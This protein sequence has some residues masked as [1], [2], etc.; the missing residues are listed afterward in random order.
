M[1]EVVTWV[2]G[3]VFRDRQE[4]ISRGFRAAID[5]GIPP[6]IAETMLLR[7]GDEVSV[8]TT[9][10]TREDLQATIGSPEEPLARRLIREAGGV[11]SV[12]IF[13][14]IERASGGPGEGTTGEPTVPSRT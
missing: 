7:D 12:R 5:A 6:G 3:N 13:E 10:R 9:W 4:E 8:L 11:P 1:G 14:V 2:S